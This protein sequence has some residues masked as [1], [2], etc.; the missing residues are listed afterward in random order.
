MK[1]NANVLSFIVFIL[2]KKNTRNLH[3][4]YLDIALGY[5]V[6]IK[7]HQFIKKYFSKNCFL[8]LSDPQDTTTV[9]CLCWWGKRGW[10]VIFVSFVQYF[11]S[12]FKGDT[13]FTVITKYWLY[14]LWCTVPPCSLTPSREVIFLGPHPRHMQVPRLGVE[15]EL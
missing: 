4:C 13:P 2:K 10:E 5:H 15:S 7:I 11:F 14:S 12:T 1:L 3:F 8:V 9:T 6:N